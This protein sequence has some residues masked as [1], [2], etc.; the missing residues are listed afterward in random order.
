MDDVSVIIVVDTEDWN[1]LLNV[2]KASGLQYGLWQKT[3]LRRL[4][5]GYLLIWSESK[6]KICTSK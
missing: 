5:D 6:L 1:I 3:V 4:Q 2:T